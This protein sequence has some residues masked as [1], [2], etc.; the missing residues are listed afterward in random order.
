MKDYSYFTEFN[1]EVEEKT[2]SLKNPSKMKIKNY[3]IGSL[4]DISSLLCY[5]TDDNGKVSD[6]LDDI[7]D[8]IT[9]NI[10]SSF[11]EFLKDNKYEGSCEVDLEST[12]TLKYKISD[13][14]L[15]PDDD[16]DNDNDPIDKFTF[17]STYKIGDNITFTVYYC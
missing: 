4:R 5:F 7:T 1:I 6:N 10:T 11:N 2:P 15:N 9:K 16:P 12:P 14:T 13:L 3:S 8:K 17:D